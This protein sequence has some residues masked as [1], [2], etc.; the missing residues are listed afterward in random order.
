MNLSISNRFV[1]FAALYGAALAVFAATVGL[2][3]FAI[4][5]LM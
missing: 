4:N 3:R 5:L 2:I 1:W